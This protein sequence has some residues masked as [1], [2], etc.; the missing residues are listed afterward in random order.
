VRAARA[1]SVLL[2]LGAGAQA[3]AEAIAV[4]SVS[5]TSERVGKDFREPAI[6]AFDGNWYPGLS[7]RWCTS[8]KRSRGQAVTA[9]FA[10]PE[11]ID[12]IQI[13]GADGYQKIGALEV[14]TDAGKVTVRPDMEGR[15]LAKLAVTTTRL[16]IRLAE[17]D[18]K[19]G[20][21]YGC[22]SDVAPS[23]GGKRLTLI[24]D[25]PADAPAKLPAAII[26]A[27]AAATSCDRKKLEA[28]AG[29]PFGYDYI[30]GD[31]SPKHGTHAD[32]AALAA[33]CS[34]QRDAFGRLDV[35]PQTITRGDPGRVAVGT[36]D[37]RKWIFAWQKSAWRLVKVEGT[38]PVGH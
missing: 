29:F 4:R 32:L 20:Q 8:D 31:D 35:P 6:Q 38:G 15:F 28:I 33:S 10:A 27:E 16:T 19:N 21:P 23:R 22:L 36:V 18:E 25:V 9:T 5:A 30:G 17:I 37:D 1:A 26:A 34:G 2:V 11:R 14:E 13:F 7:S 24:H 3:R 12:G